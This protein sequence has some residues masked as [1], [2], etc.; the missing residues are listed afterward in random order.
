[1]GINSKTYLQGIYILNTEIQALKYQVDNQDT[2]SIRWTKVCQWA[3]SLS[4]REENAEG[5]AT[6]WSLL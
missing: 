6:L 1:M 4:L 5:F 2:V 3:V